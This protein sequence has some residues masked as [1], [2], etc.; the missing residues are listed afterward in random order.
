MIPRTNN[1]RKQQN[2]IETTAP[3]RKWQNSIRKLFAFK[4]RPVNQ[5]GAGG[6]WVGTL[7]DDPQNK[8]RGAG[9]GRRTGK[10][11]ARSVLIPEGQ[12][13]GGRSFGCAVVSFF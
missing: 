2:L 8:Q 7:E 3:M 12:G 6:G 11:G 9:R 5:R 1:A 10:E 13:R 4:Q